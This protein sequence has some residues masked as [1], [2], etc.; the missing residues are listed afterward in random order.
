MFL[1]WLGYSF[2]DKRSRVDNYYEDDYYAG[3]P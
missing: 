3:A 2:M 1:S